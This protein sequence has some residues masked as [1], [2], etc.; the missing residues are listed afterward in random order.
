MATQK[1][2]NEKL[3]KVLKKWQNLEDDSIKNTTQIIKQTEN[4]L[5]HLVME[6]IRQDSVMH[7]RVQQLIIDH[8]EKQS[9]TL[10]PDELASFWTMVEEHDEL[11]KETIRLAKEALEGTKSAFAHYLLNYLMKDEQKHDE[12]LENMDKLKKNMYPYG[13]M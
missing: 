4:P 10:D 8:F 13:G 5:V 7:R 3:V 1:E 2:A 6:I 12:L 9:L 11:E